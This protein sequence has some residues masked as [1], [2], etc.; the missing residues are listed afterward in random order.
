MMG[1]IELPAS[2]L[3]RLNG[4]PAV[5]V[6]DPN[7]HTLS[8]RNITLGDYTQESIIVIDGLK[9]GEIVVTAGI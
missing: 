1:P 9:D 4:N 7:N 2:A 8:L 6:V 5:W 3:N